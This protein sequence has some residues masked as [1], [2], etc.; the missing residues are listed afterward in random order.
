[1]A[2]EALGENPDGARRALEGLCA[3]H[4]LPVAL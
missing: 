3:R 2:F 4:G 1:M